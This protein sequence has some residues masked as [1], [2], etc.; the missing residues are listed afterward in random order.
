M[1]QSI[2]FGTCWG[3]PQGQDLSSPSYMATGFQ[4]VGEAIAR[5]WTTTQGRLIDDPSYGTNITDAIGDD[6]SPAD[7][8]AL[9]TALSVEAQKD[10]RVLLC[11]V[12]LALGVD[13][14]LTA[15]AQVTT[16]VGPFQLVLTVSAVTPAT[17]L[18]S[19]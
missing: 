13:G 8:Q 17:L 18:V 3:T 10:E 4:V 5:R 1:T 14:T 12:T 19:P 9:Q 11:S 16:T 7:I 6:L 2:D 15:K